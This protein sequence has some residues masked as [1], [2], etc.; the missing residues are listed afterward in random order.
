MAVTA[1]PPKTEHAE[2]E[3]ARAA[4]RRCL[5]ERAERDQRADIVAEMLQ[6]E[7]D[8]VAGREPPDFAVG[9]RRAVIDERGGSAAECD[10]QGGAERRQ[11]DRDPRQARPAV[12]LRGCPEHQASARR[13]VQS[14]PRKTTSASSRPGRPNA[15]EPDPPECVGR[16][17]LNIGCE[18]STRTLCTA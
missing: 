8:E 18:L 12:G 11:P 15:P 13:R 5:V 2:D 17:A 7:V 14:P 1:A 10:E 4:E 16:G 6:V 9:D 3:P